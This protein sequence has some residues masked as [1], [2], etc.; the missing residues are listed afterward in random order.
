MF[1][2]W[3]IR[4]STAYQLDC[5]ELHCPTIGPLDKAQSD[6]LIVE[7]STALSDHWT[8]GQSTVQPLDSLTQHYTIFEKLDT[9]LSNHWTVGKS[10]VRP[11]D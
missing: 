9:G 11:F 1:D 8:V 2:Q 10:T 7:H 4:H 6:H 3:T 5:L